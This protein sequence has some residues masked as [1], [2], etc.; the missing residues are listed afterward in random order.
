MRRPHDDPRGE[1]GRKESLQQVAIPA[2]FGE[3]QIT[4]VPGF[5]RYRFINYSVRL[6]APNGTETNREQNTF[7]FPSFTVEDYCTYSFGEAISFCR[8]SCYTGPHMIRH[9][10]R[11]SFA[12]SVY[13][14]IRK[15]IILCSRIRSRCIIVGSRSRQTMKQS[16]ILW[17]LFS[18]EWVVVR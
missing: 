7:F 16:P 14:T 1:Q 8:C 6:N 18:H 17:T 10:E 9:S 3:L 15:R 2:F 4:G 5:R 11:I 13:G 12:M